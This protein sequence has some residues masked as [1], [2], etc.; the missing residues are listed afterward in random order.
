LAHHRGEGDI[1]GHL[2]ILGCPRAGGGEGLTPPLMLGRSME[3]V[4]D[5]S[6]YV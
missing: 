1:L 4:D 2:F 6:G 5:G 3:G